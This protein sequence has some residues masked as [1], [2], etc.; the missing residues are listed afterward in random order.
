MK[1]RRLAGLI[2]SGASWAASTGAFAHPGHEGASD[3]TGWSLAHF[4]FSTEHGLGL[5]VLVSCAAIFV[6]RG[7]RRSRR[8][9]GR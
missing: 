3:T 2:L 6:V 7:W 5:I 9:A 8:R 4:L 1:N